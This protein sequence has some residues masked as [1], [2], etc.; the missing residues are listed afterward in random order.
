MSI[1]DDFAD[2][3]LTIEA[4]REAR[5]T[6]ERLK[7]QN[8]ELRIALKYFRRLHDAIVLIEKVTDKASDTLSEIS[9]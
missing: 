8:T 6:I 1:K 9:P 3:R 4:L 7:W 5:D 2:M